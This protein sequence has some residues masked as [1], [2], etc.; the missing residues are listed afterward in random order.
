M[1]ARSTYEATVKAASA[2]QLATKV[3]NETTKQVAID[4]SKSVAGYTLQSGNFGSLQAAT[5]AA[6]AAK[7]AADYLAE[8]VKQSARDVARDTLRDSGD[9]GAA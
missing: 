4:A 1:T 3:M 7:A 6:N 8:Q 2:T 9:R 5:L